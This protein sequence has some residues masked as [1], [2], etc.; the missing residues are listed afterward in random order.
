MHITVAVLLFLNQQPLAMTLGFYV[1]SITS[2]LSPPHSTQKHQISSQ[3]MSV[4]V[5]FPCHVPV[6][7]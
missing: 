6:F 5:G 4:P 3:E 7:S 2:L 1:S